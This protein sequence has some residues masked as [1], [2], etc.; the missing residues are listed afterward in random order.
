M[1]NVMATPRISWR[2]ALAQIGSVSLLAVHVQL[3][4]GRAGE[5]SSSSHVAPSAGMMPLTASM[6]LLSSKPRPGTSDTG[7][8]RW[9]RSR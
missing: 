7:S 2:K 3:I 6:A 5:F 8:C 9:W 4:S 1:S